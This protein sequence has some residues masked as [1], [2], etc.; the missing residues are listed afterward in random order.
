MTKVINRMLLVMSVCF[1]PYAFIL[2]LDSPN[3]TGVLAIIG[4]SLV[5]IEQMREWNLM[6]K[7]DAP[8]KTAGKSNRNV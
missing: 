8:D 5:A 4:W 1:V 3:I 7:D 2:H 6:A